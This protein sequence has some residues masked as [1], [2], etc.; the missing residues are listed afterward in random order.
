MKKN[1]LRIGALLTLATALLVGVTSCVSDDVAT[2]VKKIYDNQADWIAA[3]TGLVKANAELEQARADVEKANAEFRRAQTQ[4][5]LQAAA[6]AKANAE[7]RQ[8]QADI[9]NATK[10]AQI[11]SDLAD[12]E[13]NKAAKEAAVEASKAAAE[14]SKATLE[15]NK[16]A[17]LRNK[18]ALEKVQLAYDWNLHKAKLDLEEKK[19]DEQWGHVLKYFNLYTAGTATLTQK[20]NAKVAKQ[21]ALSEKEMFLSDMLLF[22]I[23][24]DVYTGTNVWRNRTI[25]WYKQNITNQTNNLAGA[26]AAL[27]TA[28]AKKQAFIDYVN[29]GENFIKKAQEKEK[30]RAAMEAQKKENNAEIAKIAGE[31]LYDFADIAKLDAAKDLMATA[32]ISATA[33]ETAITNFHKKLQAVGLT[34]E[35]TME[36]Y[37]AKLKTLQEAASNAMVASVTASN[38]LDAAI[39]E[40]AQASATLQTIQNEYANLNAAF[41]TA[42]DDYATAKNFVD[43]G[44]ALINTALASKTT[45]Q[46]AYDAAKAD[47]EADPTGRAMS[48]GND[49]VLGN[50]DDDVNGTYMR[51]VWDAALNGGAGGPFIDSTK[52]VVHHVKAGDVGGLTTITLAQ[53]LK[54]TVPSVGANNCSITADWT[55]VGNTNSIVY[56]NVEADD[57]L[58]QTYSQVLSA[59]YNALHAAIDTY[60]TYTASKTTW[61]SDFAKAKERYDELKNLMQRKDKDQEEAQASVTA[62]H[63]NVAAK[64]TE[65]Q[66]AI[67][68]AN[69]ASNK[70]TKLVAQ[71]DNLYT[72]DVRLAKLKMDLAAAEE[73]KKSAKAKYDKLAEKIDQAT[74][75]AYE[76]KLKEKFEK[77]L[78][79]VVLANQISSTENLAKY[80]RDLEGLIQGATFTSTKIFINQKLA[81]L[82]ASIGAK[83]AAIPVAEQNLADANTDLERAEKGLPVFNQA[84]ENELKA[85]IQTLKDQIKTLEEEIAE[86]QVYIAKYKNLYDEALASIE[87]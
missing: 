21:I 77:E 64:N 10:D 7:L 28:K 15:A 59:A 25:E 62:E 43:N 31:L 81:G 83:S 78:E 1:F 14:L 74:L 49:K 61:A 86:L 33:A 48:A 30:E 39:D 19:S 3:Q 84:K 53:K 8:V 60:N 24:S 17:L 80:F 71:K 52:T 46:A 41:A 22:G 9:A 51:V 42:T 87:K 27:A 68:D 75:D 23:T 13:A 32:T 47:F 66:T 35:S 63:A 65:Y 79:N 18:L 11:A 44:D 36:D 45:A 58:G 72:A 2:E 20:Q 56:Y 50:Y 4:T 67:A 12:L 76:A 70:V 69:K 5:E 16:A 54:F 57:Q 82:N 34:A 38:T 85:Q 37:E 26:Q 55:I 73:E 40:L 6:L 29:N